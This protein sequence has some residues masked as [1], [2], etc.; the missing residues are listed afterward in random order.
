[1][2]FFND[3]SN[4]AFKDLHFSQFHFNIH[5]FSW[6]DPTFTRCYNLIAATLMPIEHRE[7]RMKTVNSLHPD[8]PSYEDRYIIEYLAD[9]EQMFLTLLNRRY[10][11]KSIKV[12]EEQPIAAILELEAADGKLYYLYGAK[13]EPFT[14]VFNQKYSLEKS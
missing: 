12:H 4:Y 11:V 14:A 2:N 3:I 9:E 10:F 8:K 7:G 1:M 5:R 6:L 13:G